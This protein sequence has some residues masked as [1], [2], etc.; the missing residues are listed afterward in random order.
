MKI[1][2]RLLVALILGFFLTVSSNSQPFTKYN[3][4]DYI[5]N[6]T[7]YAQTNY[8]PNATLYAIT[9][10]LQLDSTGKASFWLYWFFKPNVI[11]S[12]YVV[13][14]TII[15]PLPPVLF[16]SVVQSLQGAFIRPLGTTFCNS[17]ASITAAENGGGRQFRQSHPGTLI[18]GS[19]YKLPIAPDTSR[20]YW[21]YLY[22]DT[23]G[24]DFRT[25]FVDGTTCQLVTI[26]VKSIS[27][28]VPDK[29]ILSQNY[30]NPF[31]PSTKIKFSIPKTGFVTLSVYNSIGREIDKLVSRELKAGVY[32]TDF[33]GSK[34]ASGV[35]FYKL[36]AHGF[37]ETRKMLLIK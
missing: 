16:G 3:A 34:Y 32:E 14:V 31:N 8:S 2:T 29:F 5:S 28:K 19:V 36:D 24:S 10:G 20:A 30:P 23:L 21:T 25:Y 35:Y 37:S 13:T 6:A 11:D 4:K 18:T 9:S 15:S 7:A 33:D 26:G 22:V 17:D 1:F 12:S 27:S